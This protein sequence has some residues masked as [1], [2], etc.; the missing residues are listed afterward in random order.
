MSDQSLDQSPEQPSARPSQS[1]SQQPEQ[2]PEP[3]SAQLT[4]PQGGDVVD[5]LLLQHTA[6]RR[7]CD[8]SSPHPPAA[9]GRSRSARCCASWPCTR[10]SRRKSCTRT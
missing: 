1:S 8:R 4:E 6:I 9:G 2:I 10:R 5:L 3:P 7:L